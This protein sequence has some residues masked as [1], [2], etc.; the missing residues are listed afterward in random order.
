MP[1]FKKKLTEQEA[2]L[3]FIG[4][5]MNEAPSAWQAIHEDLEDIFKD[6]FVLEHEKMANL[7]LSLAAIALDLQVVR[8][9][10]PNIQAER[11]EKWVYECFN[12]G[13][14]GEYAVAE[15]KE[16]GKVFQEHTP[17]MYV[18]TLPV[19]AVSARLLHCWL[20]ENIHNFEIDMG[21][22]GDGEKTGIVSIS[23][24]LQMMVDSLLMG[25]IGN[26]KRIK[27]NF[28][29]IEGDLPLESDIQAFCVR[30]GLRD[31]EPDPES[32]IESTN[33]TDE[34]KPDD[35]IEYHLSGYDTHGNRK[36][37][38]L[39][40]KQ[41]DELFKKDLARKSYK[42]LFKGPW[43]GIKEAD[44][45]ISEA[46]ANNFVDEKGYIYGFCVYE[47][48]KPTYGLIVKQFWE[49]D[50]IIQKMSD[51]FS[52]QRVT[53]SV[54]PSLSLKQKVERIAKISKKHS[55]KIRAKIENIF[56]E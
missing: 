4:S 17:N 56:K 26:W 51:H 23:P 29:L 39:S 33:S 37:M 52:D 9:L 14:W 41:M 49:D 54:D 24:Q 46:V 7:D 53:I 25:F 5:I 35:T 11:I 27:D 55:R 40:P 16:Y 18:G 8:N 19:S 2:A 31:Y 38:W 45:P 47:K 6:Q 12:T 15:V 22:F 3:H 1:L 34:I 36:E 42:V 48:G 30:D 32:N 21:D 10:F 28:K 50:N 43:D 44:W 20:G 13:D